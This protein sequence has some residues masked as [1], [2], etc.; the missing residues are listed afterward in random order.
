MTKLLITGLL[1]GAAAGLVGALCG[2]GG[3]I[4]M[5]PAFVL[6]LGMGQKTAVATSLA[7]VVVAGLSGTINNITKSDL[8]DWRVVLITAVGAAGA[9]WYGADLMRS[10]GNAQITRIFGILLVVVGIRMLLLKA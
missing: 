9:S 8:I 2:V 10:L 1:I 7:V 5:V 3:G 4:I 6:I